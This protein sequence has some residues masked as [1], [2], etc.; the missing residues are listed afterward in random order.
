MATTEH[1]MSFAIQVHAYGGPEVLTWDE[2]TVPEPGPG[3]AKIS[4]HAVGLNF[5]DTYHRNGLYKQ[6]QLPFV[7]GSEGAGVVVAVGEGVTDIAVGDR[8]AYAGVIGAYSE[9]RLI[10]A[11]RLVKLPDAIDFNTAA[12][13]LL[14]GMTVQY[15][16][17]STYRVGPETVMLLHAA[18]GGVG[19]IASQWAAYLGATIIGTVGSDEK[20]AIAKSNGVTHAIN[21]AKENFV[22]RVREI[23]GG[24]G[25]DVVYDGV[26]RDTFPGS[27]DCLKPRGLWVTFGNSSGPVPQFEPILLMQ[28][29]SLF[30]TRPTLV[31]YTATR[32]ELLA[33]AEELFDVVRN[34]HVRISINQTYPLQQAA[35][36]HRDL[37][38][39][40]TTG[41]TVFLVDQVVRPLHTMARRAG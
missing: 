5:I 32:P 23:T 35:S 29:G 8:V 37:E 9:E 21:Y 33:S 3:Q 27:L 24:K 39:R 18:A 14:Q 25:V 20:A 7:P 13:I 4:Q 2:V 22:D 36:A 40:K 30:M 19:L 31:N 15:L 11:D 38:A 28:K 34:K 6:P 17:R 41:S 12:A 1:N 16:L 26:G 10:P